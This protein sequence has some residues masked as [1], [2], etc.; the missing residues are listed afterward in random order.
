MR[1][2]YIFIYNVYK[3]SRIYAYIIFFI[4]QRF[5]LSFFLF[6]SL[7]LILSVLTNLYT[8]TYMCHIKHMRSHVVVHAHIYSRIWAKARALA[9]FNINVHIR[10]IFAR[11]SAEVCARARHNIMHVYE[12]LCRTYILIISNIHILCKFSIEAGAAAAATS[13]G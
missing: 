10:L 13:V 11:S 2:I 5:I 1:Y 3:C 6:L 8:L 12:K 4:S 7:S 9:C